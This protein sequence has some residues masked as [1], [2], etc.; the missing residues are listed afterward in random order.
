MPLRLLEI[1]VPEEESGAV[2]HLLE[3]HRVL[4]AWRDAAAGRA[5]VQA[6]L[7]AEEAEPIMDQLEQLFSNREDFRVL[8]LPIDATLPRIEADAE[9]AAATP[10]P[11]AQETPYH[12]SREELYTAAA[13]GTKTSPVFAAMTALSA[14]VAAVGLLHNN[15]TVVI[16][17][18]VIAPLLS[19]NVALALATTL[20]D[21]RLALDALKANVVGLLIAVL[22][23]AAIGAVVTIDPTI[24]AIATRTQ[25]GPDDLVLALAAGAAGTL[26]F[27][28]GSSGA[29]IG[30]MVAVA[31]LPPLVA[32]GLLLGSW[33]P[34]LAFGAL[35]L[36]IA[37]VVCVNLAG[38]ITFLALGVRP[39]TWWEAKRAKRATRLAVLLWAGLLAILAATLFLAR[40]GP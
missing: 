25:V 32:F 13:D 27:V 40:P 7:T 5:L 19:P 6:L 3:H 26:A 8:L 2:R 17:A 10:Q 11:E 15:L 34:Q 39:R 31:L 37:N 22:L 14:V 12:L 16:G 18:M 30:V 24:P 28:S 35:L 21:L 33:H 36:L 23:S 38:V 9:A 29:V 4:G 1:V 20:G